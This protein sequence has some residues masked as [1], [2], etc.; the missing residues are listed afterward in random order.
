PTYQATPSPAMRCSHVCAVFETSTDN[1]KHW[2][3]HALPAQHIATSTVNVAL[4]SPGIQ[5]A[6]DP[7]TKGHF[8]VLLPATASSS[9]VWVTPEAG[10]SWKRSLTIAA[11]AGATVSKP[12]VS[13]GRN[14]ALGVV[15][16]VEHSDN[17]YDVYADVSSDGGS[18]FGAAVRLTRKSAPPDIMPG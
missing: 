6:A 2:K 9:E 14:G 4:T 18:S 11:P 12:W 10:R 16:R 7:A 3:R 1:G 13:F 8:A 5:V 15:W 17:T